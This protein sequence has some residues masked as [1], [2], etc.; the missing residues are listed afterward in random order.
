M[1]ASLLLLAQC[2]WMGSSAQLESLSILHPLAPDSASADDSCGLIAASHRWLNHSLFPEAMNSRMA[3][4]F[5]SSVFAC[6]ESYYRLAY[7]EEI[8][9]EVSLIGKV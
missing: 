2:F 3:I 1:L 9:P 4:V 7:L 5:D 6:V 8:S